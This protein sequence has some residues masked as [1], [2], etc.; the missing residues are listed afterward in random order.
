MVT[1]QT[2]GAAVAAIIWVALV[3]TDEIA[4]F[5]TLKD[6]TIEQLEV[7]KEVSSH[8]AFV[9][10]AVGGVIGL[11]HA[12]IAAGFFAAVWFVLWLACAD[13]VAGEIQQAK[14]EED[15]IHWRKLA[16]MIRSVVKSELEKV[17]RKGD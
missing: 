14:E 15:S 2:L 6:K 16:G 13:Y 3:F 5:V 17:S 9:G 1:I 7:R 11:Q 8:I 4:K 12:S 10:S